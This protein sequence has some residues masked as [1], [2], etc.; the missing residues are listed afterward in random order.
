MIKVGSKKIKFKKEATQWLG[1]WLD[2]QLKFPSH[3]NERVK[4]A[5]AIKIQIKRLIK[6]YGL[7][8]KLI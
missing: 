3:I 8:L 7:V 4:R 6:M 5:C 1:V 2:F